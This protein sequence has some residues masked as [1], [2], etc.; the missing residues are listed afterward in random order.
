MKIALNK[1]LDHMNYEWIPRTI[2][3][4]TS[5]KTNFCSKTVFSLYFWKKFTP[6][7]HLL[8]R[9]TS[10]FGVNI[11]TPIWLQKSWK[12]VKTA[13]PPNTIQ[14]L[15]TIKNVFHWVKNDVTHAIKL[16]LHKRLIRKQIWSDCNVIGSTKILLTKQKTGQV[17][18][19]HLNNFHWLKNRP[20]MCYK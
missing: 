3:K 9:S 19:N 12:C 6:Q 18:T 5:E 15:W 10:Y 8:F 16:K 7:I 11:T 17:L 14:N 13:P 20:R 2:R 1:K 4:K